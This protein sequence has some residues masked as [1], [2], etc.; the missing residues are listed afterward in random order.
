V[1]VS[2]QHASLI[3]ERIEREYGPTGVPRLM[4][5]YADGKATPAAFRDALDVEPDAFDRALAA[6]VR[7]RHAA[8][9]AAV[10]SLTETGGE[11]H[12]G[13][14]MAG[15]R[16]AGGDPDALARSARV[17]RDDFAAQLRAGH[18]LFS[19]G[20]HDDAEP[21]L[22]RAR[23]LYPGYVG[24]GSPYPVLAE[25]RVA[26]GDTAAGVAELQ[27]LTALNESALEANLRLAALLDARGDAAGAAE[28]L[29]RAV[30]IYPYDP[31]PHARL[32]ELAVTL[33]RS[34]LEVRERA[35]L[36]ALDPVDRAGAL[37]RLAVAR[38]R[39]GDATGARRAVLQ[40]L[41]IAPGYAEAQDLLLALS[42]GGE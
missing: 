19:D 28:A 35:A 6:D 9:L 24:P 15:V 1:G 39:A 23:T 38:R 2:Y 10:A 16:P 14:A 3:V 5:A 17:N 11:G 26:R 30:Y 27:R 29:E 34:D 20:R 12:P 31:E 42:G 40:A 8:G 7:E 13:A 25:I 4:E 18:A 21:F 37:Y 33:E 32:A 36:V 41:E 22:E